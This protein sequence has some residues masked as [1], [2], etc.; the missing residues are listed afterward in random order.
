MVARIVVKV[1]GILQRLFTFYNVE[2]DV[3]DNK[4]VGLDCPPKAAARKE[5]RRRRLLENYLQQQQMKTSESKNDVDRYLIEETINPMTS[6]FD[7]LSWLKE[8]RESGIK[9][10]G[11]VDEIQSYGFI[12]EDNLDKGQ[13]SG[14]TQDT[15]K[16]TIN[17]VEE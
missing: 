12:E 3:A 5:P 16:M 15:C 6:T 7:I 10:K 8:G 2:T 14:A 13:A 4:D 1:E 11:F 9:P 17:V